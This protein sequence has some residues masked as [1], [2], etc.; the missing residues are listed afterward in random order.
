MSTRPPEHGTTTRHH[1]A[2]TTQ[3]DLY[4]MVYLSLATH[5][6]DAQAL[7]TLLE[8]ARQA[9]A[10]QGV[11][12]MLIYHDRQF[13]QL[14]EGPRAR[15]RSLFDRIETDPRHEK[16][17]LIWEGAL[18]KRSFAEWTMGFAVVDDDALRGHPGFEPTDRP[19]PVQMPR[20]QPARRVALTLKADILGLDRRL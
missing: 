1:S 20:G 16:V 9:N 2:Q 4:A 17:D 13:L 12:G 18:D 3:P 7:Q 5:E 8:H 14:I 19:G 11:T 10:R 6:L 15:V